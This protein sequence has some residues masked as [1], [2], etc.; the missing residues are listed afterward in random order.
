MID[1]DNRCDHLDV[2][3]T[4]FHDKTDK[5]GWKMEKTIS[6]HNVITYVIEGALTYTIEN[7]TYTMQKGDIIFIPKN[8]LKQGFI[9]PDRPITAYSVFFDYSLPGNSQLPLPR[10]LH[11]GHDNNI[12]NLFKECNRIWLEKSDAY[13]LKAK[14]LLIFILHDLITHTQNNRFHDSRIEKAIKYVIN[15]YHE[16]LTVK[17][18]AAAVN[19]NPD[20]FGACFKKHTGY[21]VKEYINRIRIHKAQ[22]LL[23]HGGYNVSETACACG[24]NDIFY[25]SKVFKKI[26]GSSPTS[27]AALSSRTFFKNASD[28]LAETIQ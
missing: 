27:F 12:I 24:Y 4:Q 6:A 15:N 26:T 9:Q 3:V 28:Q 2:T 19:L 8:A 21:N 14:G 11:I 5:A 23:L 13:M 20:Y 16:H 18:L 17:K 7:D 25:F 22:D 1:I 10:T